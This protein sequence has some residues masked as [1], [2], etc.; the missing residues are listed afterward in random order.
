MKS[1]VIILFSVIAMMP[2]LAHAQIIMCKDAA[3]KTH[4]SDRPIMEC[5]D[6]SVREFGKSG[7][8]RREIPAPLT[9]EQ[10]RQKQLDEEKR[11]Q[12]QAALAEQKQADSA[13]LTRFGSEAD[14]EIARKR[15]LEIVEEQLKRQTE[16]IAAAEKRHQE[17][18]A[19][20]AQVKDPKNMPPG[21]HSRSEESG[22]SLHNEKQKLQDYKSE[23]VQINSKFDATLVRYREVTGR[24]SVAAK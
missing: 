13:M 3:G 23:I 8:L 2:L 1:T 9:A 7:V 22:K 18:Q 17:V 14:I 5:A 16:T 12:E 4:T 21:L 19:E 24:R 15:T 6:R 10:K 11:K 20:I